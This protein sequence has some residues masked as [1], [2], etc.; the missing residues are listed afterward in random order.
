[1]TIAGLCLAGAWAYDESMIRLF[2]N[3]GM[4]LLAV[5]VGLLLAG[6][7][8]PGLNLHLNGFLLAVAVYMGASVLLE[9]FVIKVALKY[10][11]ALRGGIALVTT[12]VALILANMLT[13][14]LS[15]ADW[16]TWMMAPMVVWL[17]IL[18]AG[19]I[20]PFLILKKLLKG[21]FDQAEA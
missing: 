20:L 10:A 17:S 5:V 11:P 9:P 8:L 12:L 1:M 16:Q 18:V 19:I 14:G 2:I 3:L 7:I 4:Q 15:V 6:F 21:R 13:D